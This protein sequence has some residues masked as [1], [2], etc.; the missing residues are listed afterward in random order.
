MKNSDLICS[1]WLSVQSLLA[2]TLGSSWPFAFYT[3]PGSSEHAV[4]MGPLNSTATPAVITEETCAGAKAWWDS[5]PGRWMKLLQ[6]LCWEIKVSWGWKVIELKNLKT[7][8]WM[9]GYLQEANLL[10]SYHSTPL[11]SDDGE[12]L[13][14]F[15]FSELLGKTSRESSFWNYKQY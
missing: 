9:Q 6:L 15:L 10:K 5:S 14:L 12:M 7:F 2:C 1:A 13:A 8:S 3:E 4:Q 11:P